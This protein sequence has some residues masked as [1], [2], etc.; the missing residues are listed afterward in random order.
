MHAESGRRQKLR[1]RM[2]AESGRRQK[3]R[4]RIR[5]GNR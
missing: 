2:S 1:E 3:L 5:A 4:E